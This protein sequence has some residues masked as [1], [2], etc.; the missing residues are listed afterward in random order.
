VGDFAVDTAVEGHDGRYRARLSRDWEIWGPNGGYVAAIALRAAGLATPLRRPASFAGHFLAVADFA[1]VDLE[2]AT[3]RASSRAASLRVAMTQA[4]R[5]IFQAIVWVVGE[6]AGLAHDAARMPDVPRPEALEPVETLLT[7]AECAERVTRHRFWMNF[8][9]RP[10]AWVP[11]P[12]RRAGAPC[13]REWYRYRPRATFDDPFVDAA[14]LLLLIDTMVWPAACRA[15]DPAALTHIAPSLDVTAHFHRLAPE[16][17]WLLCDAT[18]PVAADGLIGG[19]ANVWAEDG[20]LLAS[21][22][23]HML[24]RPAPRP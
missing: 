10:I 18:A 17:E 23:T 20:R 4:G 1:E 3:L 21:G 22:T 12:E 15:Y 11:W 6:S 13:W 14:R 16:S 9:E 8:E 24:C 2:V 7:P 19:G 5:P